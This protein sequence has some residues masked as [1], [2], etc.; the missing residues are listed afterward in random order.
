MGGPRKFMDPTGWRGGNTT[1]GEHRRGY[2]GGRPG[3]Y[4]KE[5]FT[6][7]ITTR[8]SQ[9]HYAIALTV[10]CANASRGIQYALEAA[11][12]KYSDLPIGRIEA[13]NALKSR[14]ERLRRHEQLKPLL[15]I[16]PPPASKNTVNRALPSEAELGRVSALQE[17]ADKFGWMDQAGVNDNEND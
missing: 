2:K 14:T 11:G 13:E 9:R 10:G 6:W 7:P 17:D 15:G 16:S 3:L 12:M 5:T 8:L 1:F 4:P